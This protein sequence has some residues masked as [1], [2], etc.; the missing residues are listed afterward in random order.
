MIIC[1]ISEAWVR[2]DARHPDGLELVAVE[3]N[4]K[5]LF[6]HPP[7]G[8]P[9]E[10][11]QAVVKAGPGSTAHQAM[12]GMLCSMLK[13]VNL[14]LN[15]AEMFGSVGATGM[16]N[17]RATLAGQHQDRFRVLWCAVHWLHQHWPH[18]LQCCRHLVLM[19]HQWCLEQQHKVDQAQQ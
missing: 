1:E 6:C 11:L 5:F 4:L 15:T 12:A 18:L 2:A 14:A 7:G 3:N 10:S 16:K 8:D 17:S 19:V 9:L 13:G